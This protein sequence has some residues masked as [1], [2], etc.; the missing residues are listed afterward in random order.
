MKALGL[1]DIKSVAITGTNRGIGLAMLKYVTNNSDSDVQIFAMSRNSSE[2]QDSLCERANVHYIKIDVTDQASVQAAAETVK[3][4]LGDAGLNVLINNAGATSADVFAPSLQTSPEE[5]YRMF[6][7]NSVSTHRVVTAFYP[8]LKASA[9]AQKDL[10][11][12]AARGAIV[13][14]SSITAS[15][16]LAPAFQRSM[17]FGYAVAKCAVNMMTKFYAAEFKEDGIAAVAV[18]PGW[19]QSDMG[20][21]GG[22]FGKG[23]ITTDECAEHMLNIVQNITEELSGYYLKKDCEKLPF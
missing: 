3:S 4:I 19:V 22:D 7:I 15:I 21:A 16:E 10:P 12:C 18:H 1:Y 13:N 14:F 5:M 6:D 2:A 23:D 11:L 9:D 20:A 17:V 8:F